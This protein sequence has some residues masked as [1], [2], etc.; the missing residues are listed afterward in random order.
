MA[1]ELDIVVWA[2]RAMSITETSIL[3]DRLFE[4]AERNGLFLAKFRMP[5]LRFGH[6]WPDVLIDDDHVTLLRSCLMKPEHVLWMD[7]I[8]DRLGHSMDDARH[9]VG[10]D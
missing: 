4:T 5:S 8:W 1:P 9:Q 6:L 2:P 3:S 7:D 10:I